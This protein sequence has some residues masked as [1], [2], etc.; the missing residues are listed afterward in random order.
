MKR[1]INPW[2]I[3]QESNLGRGGYEP[4]ALPIE[5]MIHLVQFSLNYH[6][7]SA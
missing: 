2:W 4:P 1:A 7:I 5:L 3:I 6:I